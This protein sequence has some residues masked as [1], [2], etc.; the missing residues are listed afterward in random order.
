V[1]QKER[2]VSEN[3]VVRREGNLWTCTGEDHN[4]EAVGFIDLIIRIHNE[5]RTQKFSVTFDSEGSAIDGASATFD[6]GVPDTY[7]DG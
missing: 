1:Q 5:F 4:F 7:V 2:Q 3:L 6:F